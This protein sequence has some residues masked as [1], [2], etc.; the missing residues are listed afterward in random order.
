MG[1]DDITNMKEYGVE[2]DIRK[3]PLYREI[4]EH[5][6]KAYEPGFGTITGTVGP[7]PSP[8]GRTVAFTGTR[9]EKLEGAPSTRVCLIELESGIMDEVTA[10]PNDDRA[11]RWSP[12]GSRLAFLSDR[13]EKGQFQLYLLGAGRL[14]EAVAAPRVDSTA[15]YLAWSPDG[16]TILL[17]VAGRGAD[18]AG[19]QGSGTAR[20]AEEEL[21]SWIPTVDSGVGENQW[22]RLYL[23]DI[24]AKTIRPVS[25]EGLNVWEA[26]WAGP[27]RIAAVVSEDPSE[28]AWY[29]APLALLDVQTG[30]E[31]ILY[32]STVQLGSPVS[33]PSGRRLVVLEALCSDR[34]VVAGDLLQIDPDTGAAARLDTC[35]I[36]VT[37][38]VWRDED[39]LLFSG[40]S[41]L[42]GAVCEYDAQTGGTRELWRTQESF[43]TRYPDAWPLRDGFV[44]VLESFNRY[45]EIVL[46]QDGSVR[47]ISCLEHE[48]AKYLRSCGGKMQEVAWQA[49]DGLEIQGFLLT[50]DRSGPHPLILNVH[51]GPVSA[52]RNR[53]L[54]TTMAPLL[55]SRGYAVLYPNPRGSAG[56]GQAFARLV[57]G[58][59][60][61]A[62]TY[63]HLTGIN[64]LIER[65]IADP[66]RIGVTG[67]SHGGYMTTWLITQSDHFAAAVAISPVTDMYS[68]HGTSNIGAFDRFF[69]QDE[70][71]NPGGRYFERSPVMFAKRARTPTLLIA[72]GRDRCTPAGQAIEFHRGL[73]ENGVESELVIY[74]EEGHGVRNLPALI[75]YCTRTLDWFERH[76]PSAREQPEPREVVRTIAETKR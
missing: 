19:V 64:A 68:Q 23:Y 28:D 5:F 54:G 53:W 18:L 57:L 72:G 14:G 56:R 70:L 52:V 22:R 51:G 61:G 59:V 24:T 29:S 48:G 58:D 30:K 49:A 55:L 17:G 41:G 27:G 66:S 42:E 34:A 15:E 50:P 38:A 2:R 10:G 60:G 43:G 6:K 69:L 8:D 47:Q 63:D 9:M 21:P 1:R 3:T 74:P 13:R 45:P 46:V 7:T 33:S 76:M 12:D 16:A 4:E 36:D 32:R 71:D 65:G 35:G 11:P 73:R 67:G 20:G 25:R 26:A 31:R 39:H 44:T 37:H 40:L 75:D 62:E